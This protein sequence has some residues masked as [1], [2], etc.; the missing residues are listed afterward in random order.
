MVKIAFA[1]V[2]R[3]A[4]L[5]TTGGEKIEQNKNVG[6]V[7][8]IMRLLTRNDGDLIKK[9]DKV[10][11]SQNGIKG[12]SLSRILIDDHEIVASRENFEGG[13]TFEHIFRFC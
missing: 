13:L 9:F 1:D 8:T 6:H 11:D 10:N 7:S 12:T 4:A 3:I 2:F 5:S